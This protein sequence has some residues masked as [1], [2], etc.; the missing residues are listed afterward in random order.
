MI[1]RPFQYNMMSVP[2]K[3]QSQ[4]MKACGVRSG[5]RGM[6]RVATSPAYTFRKGKWL[7][8]HSLRLQLRQQLAFLPHINH[9]SHMYCTINVLA[10]MCSILSR[11]ARPCACANSQR[12][13]IPCPCIPY[14]QTLGQ[15]GHF[16]ISWDSEYTVE[17]IS[18]SA[19][20]GVSTD[21]S[22]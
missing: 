8:Q 5:K 13:N 18:I 17:L 7:S 11:P 16:A 19:L 1:Q 3:Q 10:R 2:T 12:L 21:L 15:Y 6:C 9:A 4:E 14:T 20:R 22:G